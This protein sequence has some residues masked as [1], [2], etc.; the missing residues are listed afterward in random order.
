M[1]FCG[2]K[3]CYLSVYEQ[4]EKKKAAGFVKI[5]GQGERAHFSIQIKNAGQKWNELADELANGKITPEEA[6]K[7][8]G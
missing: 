3:V 8:Y 1:F 7:I 6:M 2:K 4:K 5:S